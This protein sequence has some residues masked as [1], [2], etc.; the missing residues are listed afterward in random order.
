PFLALELVAGGSLADRMVG[1]PWPPR[2]AA[3]TILTVAEAVEHAHR[4]GIVHCDLKP[5]NILM[6]GDGIPKV[7]DF[8]VAKWIESEGYWKDGVGRRGTPRYMA[9]EQAGGAGEVGPAT[10]VY[11]LG[12]ILY[13]MLAG[14]VPLPD[15]A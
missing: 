4:N 2:A 9:P 8:G 14:R 3:E 11:S 5:S 7:A 10:D 1:E 6:T 12:K 13:E 15:A